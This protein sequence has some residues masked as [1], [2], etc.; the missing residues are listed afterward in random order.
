[1]T[2]ELKRDLQLLKMRSVLDSKR[3]YKK[4][5]K[6]F[7]TPEFSQV[8]TVVEGPTE[9]YSARIS[10]KDRS[11]TIAEGLLADKNTTGQFRRKYGEVQS[12][13]SSGKKAY[14][15][16]QQAKRSKNRP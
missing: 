12:K 13:K 4:D 1:L 16:A 14:Y 7:K 9:F 2:P 10:R 5:N 3:H 8:G 15:K 6:K 11:Q